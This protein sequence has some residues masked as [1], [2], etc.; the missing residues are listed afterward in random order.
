MIL[1]IENL[2]WTALSKKL[3]MLSWSSHKIHQDLQQASPVYETG[4]N[5]HTVF[6]APPFSIDLIVLTVQ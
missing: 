5:P 4:G 6:L 3:G 2:F 1:F